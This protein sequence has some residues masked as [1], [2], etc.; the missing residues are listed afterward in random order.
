MKITIVHTGKTRL[1]YIDSG[2]K[3]YYQRISKYVNIT[4]QNSSEIKSSAGLPA[5]IVKSKE[6]EQLLKILSPSDYL[7]LFD[8]RGDQYSSV[9]FAAWLEKSFMAGKALVFATGGA[10]GFSPAV[11]KRAN[12][13]I[14]L[15][16]MTFPHQLVRILVAEQ[17]YR[18][19]TIMRGEKYHH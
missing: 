1:P 13:K 19:I 10:F 6:G 18:A 5:D 9:E 14:S 12:E 4:E 16:L 17:L 11:Y 2:C 15:S 7:I 3:E 8:E